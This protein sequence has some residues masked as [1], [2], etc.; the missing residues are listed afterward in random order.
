MTDDRH[1]KIIFM[2][3][4]FAIGVMGLFIIHDTWLTL[5]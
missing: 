3:I 1:R 2:V 5:G 4:I